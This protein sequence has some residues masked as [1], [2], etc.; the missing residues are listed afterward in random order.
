MWWDERVHA[1]FGLA[2][3]TFKGGYDDF[4]EFVH[5]EDRQK[6]RGEFERGIATRTAVDTEFHVTWPSD[7]SGA[8]LFGDVS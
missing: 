1:L 2:P 8:L 7:A 3:G 6:I 4:L 5:E